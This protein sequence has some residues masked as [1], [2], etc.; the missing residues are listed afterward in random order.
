MQPA[1]RF[2]GKE[3]SHCQ[4]FALR[5][6]RT[7]GGA[8]RKDVRLD[9]GF[10]LCCLVTT[11][12]RGLDGQLCIT[13][14]RKSAEAAGPSAQALRR[15]GDLCFLSQRSFFVIEVGGLSVL[16]TH[17]GQGGPQALRNWG[18]PAL[19]LSRL[20]TV[21][22]DRASRFPLDAPV[23][24]LPPEKAP[25]QRSCGIVAGLQSGRVR[26]LAD[27]GKGPVAA[28]GT[29]CASPTDATDW[30]LTYR[31]GPSPMVG[32]CRGVRGPSGR[33]GS[34]TRREDL[35]IIPDAGRVNEATLHCDFAG[36]Q[37]SP[38]TPAP[39]AI[40]A[41]IVRTSDKNQRKRGDKARVRT[42][43][44]RRLWSF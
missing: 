20:E 21:S 5:R 12:R 40:D 4:V 27:G 7:N 15:G 38:P 18:C 1:H 19:L 24:S 32:I 44:S 11:Q 29:N 14:G 41:T 33:P 10:W 42:R 23:L 13:T 43:R 9:G 16:S 28:L 22:D 26:L 39:S 30:A 25:R 17:Q 36:A 8:A 37:L 31:G 34:A 35:G 6:L 2:L 3:P